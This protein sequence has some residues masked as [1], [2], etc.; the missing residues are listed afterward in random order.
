MMWEGMDNRP[1]AWRIVFKS[2]TLLE[3]LIKN[4]SERCVDE[5]RGRTHQ[6]R[7]LDNFNYYEGTVDR[8]LGVREKSKQ[9]LE[10]LEDDERIRE[11]RSKAKKLREKFGGMSS[12]SAGGGGGGGFGNTSSSKYAGYGNDSDF[13]SSGYGNSSGGY[14]DSGGGSG[15]GSGSG[16]YGNGGLDSY[17]DGKSKG[18]SGRYADQ[19]S[20]SNATKSQATPT[21]ATLPEDNETEEKPVKKSSKPKKLKKKKKKE[22]SG[23]GEG[24]TY[25]PYF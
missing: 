23:T 5:A 18:F 10:L 1:A 17:N 15:S 8:G 20:T 16:G 12:S 14:S 7:G 2:L 6:L 25:S 21:F 13:R 19:D 3:H 4:G 24:K 22:S 9:I 11:E